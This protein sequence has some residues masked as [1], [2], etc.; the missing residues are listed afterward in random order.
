MQHRI[1]VPWIE[2][3]DMEA[4][5]GFLVVSSTSKLE[6]Q[7][8]IGCDADFFGI[9]GCGSGDFTAKSSDLSRRSIRGSSARFRGL[10]MPARVSVLVDSQMTIHPDS[11]EWVAVL[12]YDVVGGAL[13]RFTSGCRHPGRRPRTFISRGAAIN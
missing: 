3:L 7:G 11:A 10:S 13:T 2:W 8:A 1:A 6:M 5:A 4:L 12:R 9:L